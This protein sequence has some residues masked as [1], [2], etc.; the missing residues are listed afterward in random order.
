MSKEEKFKNALS[1]QY[2]LLHHIGIAANEGKME[3]VKYRLKDAANKIEECLGIQEKKEFTFQEV[4]DKYRALRV[5]DKNVIIDSAIDF[6]QQYNG[7]SKTSC[8]I[9]AMG[10]ELTDEENNLYRKK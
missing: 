9:L 3:E 4:L 5:D 1:E 7:R 2:N 6:M 10:Y 8:I